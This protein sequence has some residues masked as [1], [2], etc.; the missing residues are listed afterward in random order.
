LPNLVKWDA[1]YRL[2]GLV[3]IKVHEGSKEKLEETKKESA[4]GGVKFPVGYDDGDAVTKEY[5]VQGCPSGF[6]IG[7]DGNV[8]WEGVVDPK[9]AAKAE[10]RIVAEL[11]KVTKEE[12]EKIKEEIKGK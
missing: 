12:Q 7:T 8:V 9:K 6:L 10:E 2:K 1:S 3:V 11:K 5:G 4:K